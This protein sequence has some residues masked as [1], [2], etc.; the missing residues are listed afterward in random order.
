M[1]FLLLKIF[2]THQRIR[3]LNTQTI[4]SGRV[5]FSYY[6]T[7]FSIEWE[8]NCRREGKIVNTKILHT[9]IFKK[10]I[11]LTTAVLLSSHKV[12]QQLPVQRNQSSAN[13]LQTTG[14]REIFTV[15]KISP[16]AY[17]GVEN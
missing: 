8:I 1:Q 9:N 7:Y 15:N 17:I 13:G 4:L 11:F 5:K 10:Y 6:F 12:Y 3:K 2:R 16:V 14:D